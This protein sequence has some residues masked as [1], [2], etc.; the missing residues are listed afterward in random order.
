MHLYICILAIE[1]FS[2]LNEFHFK[3]VR[4]AYAAAETW[5]PKVGE[6]E[7]IKRYK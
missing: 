5:N 2:H 7:K 3:I 6:S 1:N 4:M